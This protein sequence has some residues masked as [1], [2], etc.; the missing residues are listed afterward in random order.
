MKV[1]LCACS[2]HVIE[3]QVKAGFELTQVMVELAKAH[4]PLSMLVNDPIIQ[5]KQRTSCVQDVLILSLLEHSPELSTNCMSLS[6]SVLC[7]ALLVSQGTNRTGSGQAANRSFLLT[8]NCKWNILHLWDLLVL[9]SFQQERKQKWLLVP[10]LML[11]LADGE[12]W[13]DILRNCCVLTM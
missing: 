12:V 13:T 5:L 6:S 10:Q 11:N 3:M 2:Q 7:I 8:M 9:F 1:H 4:R